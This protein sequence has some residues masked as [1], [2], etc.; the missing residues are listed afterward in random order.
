MVIDINTALHD[1]LRKLGVQVVYGDISSV[2]VMRHAGVE[3][4]AVIV[5]TVPDTLL[6]GTNN[7]QLVRQMRALAPDAVVIASATSVSHVKALLDAGADHAYRPPA[8]AAFGLL[9]AV[10]A[11]LDG[12]LP[13]YVDNHRQLHGARDRH[14]EVID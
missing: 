4:A 7:V 11:A 5:S 9:P 1:Q 14:P 12:E 3:S 6:K 2:E 13:A 10:F 8:E